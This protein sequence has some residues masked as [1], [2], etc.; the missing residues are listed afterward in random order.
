MRTYV[1]ALT[2]LKKKSVAGYRSG[3]V[4]LGHAN[5]YTSRGGPCEAI[6][7]SPL[8]YTPDGLELGALNGS[9]TELLRG[10]RGKVEGKFTLFIL[11]E[12]ESTRW[13]HGLECDF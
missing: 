3:T 8:V 2:A 11:Q 4:C 1:D 7:C 10:Q 5:E 13:D 6:I 9:S 12:L